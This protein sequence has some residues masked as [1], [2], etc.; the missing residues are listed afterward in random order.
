MLR[1]TVAALSTGEEDFETFMLKSGINPKAGQLVRWS[2]YR[3]WIRWNSTVWMMA[4]NTHGPLNAKRPATAELL[5]AK[6]VA[7]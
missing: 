3:S 1:W 5:G 7:L 4:I 6:W 2:V